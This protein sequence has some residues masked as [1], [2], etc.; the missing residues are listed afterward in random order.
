MYMEQKGDI[1]QY[2]TDSFID[3]MK[4]MS[5]LTRLRIFWVLHRAN[6]ELCVCEVIDALDESQYNVSRHL[7]ILKYAGLVKERKQ[8]RFVYYSLSKTGNKTHRILIQL[9][10]TV[11][12]E[13]LSRDSMRL[14]KRLS[15]RKDNICVVGMLKNK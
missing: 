10:S 6:T 13:I 5:D 11:S 1:M 9:V 4:A 7:K 8:G 14:T 12:D 2:L 3:I 15:L